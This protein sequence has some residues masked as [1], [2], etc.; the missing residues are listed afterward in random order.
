MINLANKI[1]RLFR[2]FTRPD[3]REYTYQEVEEGTGKAVT[4]TYVWKLRTGKATNPGY[5]VLKALSEFFHVPVSYFFDEAPSPDYVQELK[6]AAR[7]RKAGVAHIAL[8]ASDLDA[9]GRQAVL[10]MIEYVRKAQGLESALH[11]EMAGEE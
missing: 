6:L 2:E 11:E 1:D 9:R 8:R 10:E 3:G 7:L 5:R 4:G